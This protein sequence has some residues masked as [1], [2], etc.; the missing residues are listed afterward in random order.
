MVYKVKPTSLACLLIISTAKHHWQLAPENACLSFNKLIAKCS[1]AKPGLMSILLESD[2]FVDLSGA[3]QG[4]PMTKRKIER[5]F[6]ILIKWNKINIYN[7]K[8]KKVENGISYKTMNYIGD[9]IKQVFLANQVRNKK[10]W[11]N[12]CN[13][14][15]WIP[16][17]WPHS[18]SAPHNPELMH[19]TF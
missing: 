8:I 13:F 4:N 1:Y 6:F 18:R 9:K 2:W 14:E 7:N 15:S 5:A 17:D 3:K 12:R 19:L 16:V 11:E 10:Q